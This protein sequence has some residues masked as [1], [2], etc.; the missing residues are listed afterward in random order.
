[1]YECAGDVDGVDKP[2]TSDES[3]VGEGQ[4]AR[5]LPFSRRLKPYHYAV[6]AGVARILSVLLVPGPV[7]SRFKPPLSE[8]LGH[9][10][11]LALSM[12]AFGACLMLI[13]YVLTKYK[14]HESLIGQWFI[15]IG[16]FAGA[17]CLWKFA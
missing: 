8:V 11:A 4:G 6:A 13:G 15:T 1:M 9:N 5:A 3:T 7:R 2:P 14:V 17:V 12:A 16:S 10:V